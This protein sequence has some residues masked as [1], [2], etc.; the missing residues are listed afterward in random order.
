MAVRLAGPKRAHNEIS[1]TWLA[2]RRVFSSREDYGRHS[3]V[4][5][6]L[7]AELKTVQKQ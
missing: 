7:N 3:T 6:A 1:K 2:K 4:S 5:A